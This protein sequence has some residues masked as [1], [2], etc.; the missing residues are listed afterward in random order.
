M[1]MMIALPIP[2]EE[3]SYLTW[4]LPAW[5]IFESVI[6]VLQWRPLGRE[7][8]ADYW[9]ISN[10]DDIS[11]NIQGWRKLC[12][13]YTKKTLK[14]KKC[15]KRKQVSKKGAEPQ[16]DANEALKAREY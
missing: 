13:R 12:S 6:Y 9:T 5:W 7:I 14:I 11:E 2:L 15:Q 8:T 4:I 1:N 3:F 10:T 16:K